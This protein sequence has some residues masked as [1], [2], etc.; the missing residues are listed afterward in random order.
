MGSDA[1]LEGVRRHVADLG[2]EL[3]EFRKAGPP[4]T[5]TIQVRIDR[6]GSTP[7]HGVTADD[8]ARVSRT[9][10]RWFEGPGGVGS[11]YLLQVSSPGF[12]RPVRFPEH[13]R[14][15]VGRTVRLTARALAGHP[16]AVILEVPDEGHV[17]LRLPDGA[18]QVVALE[19]VKLA[20]LQ[21][22]DDPG[23][24]SRREP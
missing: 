11:R 1:I 24:S 14:R 7:G 2:F 10:E 9:L 20:E 5:P 3:I 17:R 6:P 22:A 18:E 19:D 23:A 13:W 8:C 12:T 16:R 15:Y 4:R 21:D